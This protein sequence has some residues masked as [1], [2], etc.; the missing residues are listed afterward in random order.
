MRYAALLLATLFLAWSERGLAQETP[1]LAERWRELKAEVI[2]PE[3]GQFDLSPV[4]ERAHG[5][6]PIPIVVTEPAVGFGGGLAA[7]FIQPRREVGEEGFHRPDLSVVGALATENGTRFAFAGD[8][9]RWLG[10]RLKT[11]AGAGAGDIKL[12]FYGLG[13][14]AEELDEPIRYTL[15]VW[16]AIAQA[17]WQL[18]PKSPWSAG[19]RLVYADVEPK[20][21][22]Q[23]LFPDLED[24]I[25]VK[26]SGPSLVLTYDSRDNFF[27]PTA[28]A[29]SET[30][31]LF[32]NDAFGAT[33]DFTRFGQVLMGWWPVAPKVTLGARADYQQSSSGAPFFM[34]PYIALR[35]IP[36]MRYPGNKVASGELEVRWQF[37]GRWSVVAFGGYGEARIDDRPLRRS[38]TAG[39]GGLGFRYELARKFGLH[40]GIDVARGPE[41]TAV[42]LQVG[43]AW[44][45]P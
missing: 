30:S 19:L 40:A 29:Y 16:G 31:I 10:G 37:H 12:D 41:D 3:D 14:T 35:G 6:L 9:R 13:D 5:F 17:D 15:A 2:D 33:T 25:R 27:T 44:V 39:A 24:R 26:I 22:D 23:P 34:R 43:S 18:A 8:L 32:S 1:S 20:L 45:R 36:A 21:R 28:G 11:M 7:L 4:L 38:Q 42:Y